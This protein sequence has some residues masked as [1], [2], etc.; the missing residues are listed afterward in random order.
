MLFI[1]AAGAGSAIAFACANV[2]AVG[3]LV[4][5][6]L[7]AIPLLLVGFALGTR[8][9][10]RASLVAFVVASLLASVGNSSFYAAF[11]VMPVLY[12]VYKALLFRDEGVA[13]EWYP[14]TTIMA[15]LSAI[16]AAIFLIFSIVAGSVGHHGLQELV[17]KELA[18]DM[19]AS[20]N[21][22]DFQNVIK[23]LTG[24]GSFLLFASVGWSW[25][26][27][28]Y[29]C[30]ML[31]HNILEPARLALRDNLTLSPYGLP[32]WLLGMVALNGAFAL[33]G[34][35]GDRFVGETVFL[36]LLLPYFLAGCARIHM[37]AWRWHNRRIWLILFY[38]LLLLQIWLGALV[39]VLGL[40]TQLVEI[41]DKRRQV[42]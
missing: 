10:L 6:Y 26:L 39:A 1:L 34:Q 12:F 7:P 27:M 30:A 28:L 41:L 40:Y 17:G 15:E 19:A 36:I 31:C 13:R 35:G 38:T 4:L 37:L 16:T 11:T 33:W 29:V 32:G 8:A 9:L 22:A 25:A 42:G 5:I 21:N 24:E 14:A 23:W 3:G 20:S 18:T 2:S